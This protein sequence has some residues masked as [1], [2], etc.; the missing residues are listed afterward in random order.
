[1]EQTGDY[2]KRGPDFRDVPDRGITSAHIDADR[3]VRQEWSNGFPNWQMFRAVDCG[4]S[5]Y[6]PEVRAWCVAYAIA[7]CE[8][9]GVRQGMPAE[10]IGCLAGWD[11][12]YALMNHKWLI[13]GMDVADA[14][15]LTPRRTGRFGTTSICRHAGQP[16]ALLERAEYRHP[17]VYRRYRDAPAEV[18]PSGLATAGVRARRRAFV[19]WLLPGNSGRIGRLKSLRRFPGVN[20]YVARTASGHAPA[21]ANI[22]ASRP[23]QKRRAP[24]RRSSSMA[25]QPLLI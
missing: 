2:D 13:A 5:L 11:A 24:F 19:G 23:C 1:M 7:Y 20:G 6:R 4:D 3:L 22:C 12:Y 17:V 21:L 15:G 16:A 25:E 10:E 18:P 14:A 9:G 8:A